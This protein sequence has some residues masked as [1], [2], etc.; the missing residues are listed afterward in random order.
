MSDIVISLISVCGSLLGSLL[1]IITS[2]KLTNY[3]LSELEKKVDKHNNFAEKIPLLQQKI[4]FIEKE[5]ENE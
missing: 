4:D 3:R 1:G 5:F 2:A